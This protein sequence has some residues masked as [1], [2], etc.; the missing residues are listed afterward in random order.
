MDPR[1]N[2]LLKWSIE[3]TKT[4]SDGQQAPPPSTNLQQLD[5]ELIKHILGGPSDAERMKDAMAAI[6]HPE[7]DLEN[8]L[9]A[10][11]NFEQMVEQIDNANNLVPLGL[12]PPLVEQLEHDIA[13]LRAMAA[14]CVGTA[15]QN[16]VKAQESLHGLGAIPKL[17][18]LATEDADQTVRK[19]AILALSSGIRNFQPG[20]NAFV[21]S[22]PEQHKVEGEIDATDM[23]AIDDIIRRLR[24]HSQQKG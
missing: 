19:K 3:N 22:L 14:W 18:Q 1:L 11:D 24:E 5:P 8:K 13:D 15:V 23:E 2:D 17:V 9:I 12:W 21:E 4:G 16:N 20:V 6:L 10:F 7:I